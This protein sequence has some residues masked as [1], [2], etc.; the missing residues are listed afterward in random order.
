MTKFNFQREQIRNVLDNEREQL[1]TL[2][3]ENHKES[4]LVITF[5]LDIDWG[6]LIELEKTGTLGVYSCRFEEKLVG[7]S[8][9][10]ADTN[11]FHK[12]KVF[13]TIDPIFISK[14]YRLNGSGFK[15]LKFILKDLKS[16]GVTSV[17]VSAKVEHSFNSLLKKMKLIPTD[18]NY[19]KVL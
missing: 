5:P 7:Y 15:F 1:E 3:E 9:V 16:L 18:I 4:R 17:Q 8:L 12:D 14:R 2:L 19:V 13:A 11:V 10:F 6:R